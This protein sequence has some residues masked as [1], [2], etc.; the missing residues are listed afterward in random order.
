MI[1]KKKSQSKLLFLV[2]QLVAMSF[3][4]LVLIDKQTALE[5]QRFFQSLNISSDVQSL[6]ARVY[7]AFKMTFDAPSFVGIFFVIIH[8]VCATCIVYTFIYFYPKRNN[9]LSEKINTP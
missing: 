8:V 2:L 6:M 7:F 4:F 1:I 5:I 9:I 3:L